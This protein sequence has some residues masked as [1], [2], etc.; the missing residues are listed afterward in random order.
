MV[1]VRRI[2]V[3][4]KVAQGADETGGGGKGLLEPSR[5]WCF[6]LSRDPPPSIQPQF[7]PPL[8]PRTPWY[9]VSLPCKNLTAYPFALLQ[10]ARRSCPLPR[11]LRQL[12]TPTHHIAPSC[13]IISSCI[14][15]VPIS[16]NI[17]SIHFLPPYNCL[18]TIFEHFVF[19]M[20]YNACLNF[21]SI[22]PQFMVV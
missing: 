17:L 5:G 8:H 3:R 14:R 15:M 2:N 21:A 13:A 11:I 7:S 19:T 18:V 12:F 20:I 16:S 4:R 10:Y 9:K 1:L 22:L 6:L